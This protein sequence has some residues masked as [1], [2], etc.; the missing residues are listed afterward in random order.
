MEEI[1]A[2]LGSV[3]DKMNTKLGHMESKTQHQVSQSPS[4]LISRCSTEN[5]LRGRPRHPLPLVHCPEHIR[6]ACSCNFFKAHLFE[7]FKNMV[8][9]LQI[10]KVIYTH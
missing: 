5:E 3:Q 2:E 8:K 9:L 6:E 1:R 4:L 10:I 7:I